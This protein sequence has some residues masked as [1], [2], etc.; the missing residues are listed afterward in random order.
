MTALLIFLGTL[1]VI[2]ERFATA[3]TKKD[4]N[5]NVFMRNNWALFILHILTSIG[6]Y[7]AAFQGE[8]L[9]VWKPFWDW[10]L[11]NMVIILSGGASYWIWKGA[12]STF[13]FIY[14]LFLGSLIEKTKRFFAIFAKTKGNR[15]DTMK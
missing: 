12:F 7:F 2:F 8:T 4:F 14:K 9:P 11:F 1:I 5:I 3:Q 10:N 15:Y 13:K 6:V